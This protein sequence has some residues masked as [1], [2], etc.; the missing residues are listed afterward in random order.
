MRE[1]EKKK[2]Q[3]KSQ[4]FHVDYGPFLRIFMRSDHQGHGD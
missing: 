2:T 3:Q 4:N 1:E